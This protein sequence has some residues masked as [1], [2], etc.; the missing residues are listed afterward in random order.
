MGMERSTYVSSLAEHEALSVEVSSALSAIL[1]EISTSVVPTASAS[2]HAR[3]FL[4]QW[5]VFKRL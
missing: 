1:K 2:K 3:E 5:P 4:D